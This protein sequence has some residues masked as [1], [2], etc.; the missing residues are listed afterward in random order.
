LQDLALRNVNRAIL[1]AR[2]MTPAAQAEALLLIAGQVL[3]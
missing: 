3:G 2:K 1:E